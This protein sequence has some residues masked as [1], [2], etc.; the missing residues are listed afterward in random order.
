[1]GARADTG[2]VMGISRVVLL[3]TAVIVA[4]A[5]APSQLVGFAVQTVFPNTALAPPPMGGVGVD[6]GVDGDSDGLT[7]TLTPF[8]GFESLAL[9]PP[10]ARAEGGEFSV[11]WVGELSISTT[12][13]R[14]GIACLL[15]T[16]PSPRD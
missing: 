4:G 8:V 3:S 6:G 15:Y 13:T 14:F 7:K 9:I 2:G 16:S 1:M 12:T 5:S 11:V 10:E